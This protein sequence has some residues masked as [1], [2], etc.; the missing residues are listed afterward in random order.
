MGKG[1]R[2]IHT[3]LLHFGT[4]IGLHLYT[5]PLVSIVDII[6]FK[7]GNMGSIRNVFRT[8]LA[9]MSAMTIGILM[10]GS[11]VAEKIVIATGADPASERSLCAACR[12]GVQREGVGR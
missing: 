1:N 8:G 7:E 9:M 5:K 12:R 2:S 3:C 10:S 11:A 4:R 6:E